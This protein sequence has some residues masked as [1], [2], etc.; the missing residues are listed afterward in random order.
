MEIGEEEEIQPDAKRTGRKAIH[1]EVVGNKSEDLLI[2]RQTRLPLSD[3]PALLTAGQKRLAVLKETVDKHAEKLAAIQ[4]HQDSMEERVR[5]VTISS[6]AYKL[7]RNCF[8]SAFKRDK[9]KC[10]T[11]AD[12]RILDAESEVPSVGDAFAD[13]RLYNGTDERRD[14]KV[15]EK[16]YGFHPYVVQKLDHNPTIHVLNT[17]AGVLASKHKIGSDKFYGL[18]AEF[19]KQFTGSGGGYETS[20]LTGIP[21][22]VTRAYYEFIRSLDMEVMAVEASA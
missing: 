8:L 9:L 22:D 10:A 15:F 21:T 1:E 17:H 11:K 19:V 16:L 3:L 20:Y 13:C 14:F 12:L 18:F 5:S 2:G 4:L 6:Y 7:R